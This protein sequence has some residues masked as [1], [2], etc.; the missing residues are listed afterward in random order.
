MKNLMKISYIGIILI[1]LL[2]VSCNDFL[3]E[4]PSKTSNVEIR[5]TKHLDM[6]LANYYSLAGDNNKAM[7]YSSDDYELPIDLYNA[8]PSNFKQNAL[9][10]YLWDINNLVLEN[11]DDCFEKSYSKIFIANTV[12][13]YVD[14]VEGSDADKSRLK[15][16]AHFI[17]AYENWNLANTYCMPYANKYFGT[18]GLSKKTS[19]SYE[20]S[21]VRMTLKETYD[22]I[23]EDL[24]AALKSQ[25]NSIDKFWRGNAY[26]I[27]G[28][29]ARYML[30]KGDYANALKYAEEVL[31]VKSYLLDYNTEMTYGRDYKY[32][33]NGKDVIVKVP[34][35]Y[36][37]Q[38]DLGDVMQWK[39]NIYM[40]YLANGSEWYIPSQN[41]LNMYDK[42]HDL[43]YKYHVVENYSYCRSVSNFSAPAYVFFYEGKMPSGITTASLLLIKAECYAR[44]GRTKDAMN[45]I[46]VLRAKRMSPGYEIQTAS[47]KDDAIMKVLAERRREMP[48][49]IRWFDIRRLNNNETSIDDV[50]LKR[51][52]YGYTSTSVL[53]S[54][55]LKDYSLT[56]KRYAA[57]L[58]DR[59]IYLS[60]G[61][62]K[63]NDY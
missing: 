29:M 36:S 42:Q 51:R 6:L 32:N 62:L 19:T 44:L 23:D 27:K 39:E 25:E 24:Q 52:F 61:E 17:R 30:F 5:T 4:M 15:A 26:A 22:F 58:I 9:M 55:S 8:R 54:G 37:Q 21:M 38:F 16:E 49:S 46:N 11:S 12:L 3:D 40:R 18:I 2:F 10:W 47:S 63:Q 28:F 56:E 50:V 45:A 14:K 35:T 33:I 59:E 13:E 53:N 7:I 43:R 48:F 60:N 41:L 31:A 1:S 57:P 34:S 20:Q